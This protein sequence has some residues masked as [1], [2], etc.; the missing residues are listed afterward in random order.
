MISLSDL[1]KNMKLSNRSYGICMDYDLMTLTDLINFYVQ[2][3][4]F[5]KLRNCG[6]KSNAELVA[7]CKAYDTNEVQEQSAEDGYSYVAAADKLTEEQVKAF[8]AYINFKAQSLSVRSYNGLNDFAKS[9][10]NLKQLIVLLDPDFDLRSIKNIGQL[11]EAELLAFLS[12]IRNKLKRPDNLDADIPKQLFINQFSKK[13]RCQPSILNDLYS[14]CVKDDKLYL[15]AFIQQLFDKRILFS[16]NQWTVFRTAFNFWNHY[17]YHPL[18]EIS[19]LLGLTDERVRQI[20]KNIYKKLDFTFS[21][22]YDIDNIYYHTLDVNN[23]FIDVNEELLASI[24]Q[25]E[26]V[27]F[28]KLFILKMLSIKLSKSHKLIGDL[29]SNLY[30]TNTTANYQKS[31]NKVFLVC[32]EY[33][34]DYDLK[35]L[36]KDMYKRIAVPS[37]KTYSLPLHQYL[38]PFIKK[39]ADTDT[40]RLLD[41]TKFV[42]TEEFGPDLISG[43]HIFF[44]RNKR[45]KLYEHIYEALCQIDAPATVDDIYLKML[46]INP[47]LPNSG[48]SV[49]T[50]MIK[51]SDVFISFGK[52]SIYGLKEWEAT[53]NIRGGTIKQLAIEYLQTQSKPQHIKEILAYVNQFRNTNVNNLITNLRLDKKN[54]FVFFPKQ[55]VGLTAKKHGQEM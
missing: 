45:V 30:K 49:R 15:F 11:S 5:L 14:R 28:N 52:T 2:N 51:N 17:S 10:I 8:D 29:E 35:A 25:E 1:N 24:Q 21:F 32:N 50:T 18:V 53:K 19:K 6:R 9:Q 22:V 23:D 40:H 41:I 54:T 46:E 20:R 38:L 26:H 13:I 48:K 47:D 36:F 27:N 39:N 34:K 3:K 12:D 16:E 33:V 43:D 31:F 4:S 7:I 55:Y 37:S 44:Y 42:I